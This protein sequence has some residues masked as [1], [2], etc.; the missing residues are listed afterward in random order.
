MTTALEYISCKRSTLSSDLAHAP[1]LNQNSSYNAYFSQMVQK[2]KLVSVSADERRS[3][4]PIKGHSCTYT[5]D[6]AALVKDA[7]AFNITLSLLEI[8]ISAPVGQ[9]WHVHGLD[10]KVWPLDLG[11]KGPPFVGLLSCAGID[12]AT[13]LDHQATDLCLQLLLWHLLGRFILTLSSCHLGLES[14][15]LLL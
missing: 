12:Q 1:Y 9:L 14:V 8:E 6:K 7:D 5:C 2:L 13:R 11:L 10:M 4:E 3:G 15:V